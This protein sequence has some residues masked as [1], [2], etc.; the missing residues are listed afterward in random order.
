MQRLTVLAILLTIGCMT[1]D[2]IFGDD[3]T[4]ASNSVE[5]SWEGQVR[6]DAADRVCGSRSTS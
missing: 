5:G 2:P 4:V 1:A 3:K 6:R